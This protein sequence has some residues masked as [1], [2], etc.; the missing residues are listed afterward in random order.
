MIYKINNPILI[1]YIEVDKSAGV[2]IYMIVKTPE[3]DELSPI[4]MTDLGNGLYEASFIPNLVGW[5]HV[6]IYC[7]S[8][9]K[10]VYSKSYFVGLGDFSDPAKDSSLQYII[11]L[12]SNLYLVDK[13]FYTV[14]TIQSQVSAN[15]HH[16]IL[17]NN[18]QNYILYLTRIFI[19]SVRITAVTSYPIGVY[20]YSISQVPSGGNNLNIY[21]LD[22]N[23]PDVVNI[24]ALNNGTVAVDNLIWTGSV[25]AEEGVFPTGVELWND[26]HKPIVLRYNQGITLKQYPYSSEG[27]VIASVCFGVEIL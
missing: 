2:S 19:S 4:L 25:N 15:K 21:K 3:G 18:N 5:W 16:L 13:P 14:S 24:I 20:L 12:F 10:N 9:P 8:K 11:N 22:S 1:R 6:R 7:P 17:F 26:K 23:H 27:Y